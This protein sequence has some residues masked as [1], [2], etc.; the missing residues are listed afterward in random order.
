VGAEGAP[1]VVAVDAVCTG[2]EPELDVPPFDA[3]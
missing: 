3:E 2:A 1:V